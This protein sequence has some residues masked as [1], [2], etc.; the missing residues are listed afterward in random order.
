M[1][2]TC[3]LVRL[4]LGEYFL[5]Y[6]KKSLKNIY[7]NLKKLSLHYYVKFYVKD[8]KICVIFKFFEIYL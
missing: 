5:E 2:C 8:F 1:S 3:L 4:I 6:F 7:Q